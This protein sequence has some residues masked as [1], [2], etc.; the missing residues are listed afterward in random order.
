MLTQRQKD[1]FDFIVN[2]IADNGVSPTVSEIALGVGGIAHAGA[3]N[4]VKVLIKK[5]YIETIK[6]KHRSICIFP[7]EFR[8]STE[9]KEPKLK[10]ELT[11]DSVREIFEYRDGELFWKVSRGNVLEGRKAGVINKRGYLQLML[12]KKNYLGH[13]I[14]FLIHHGY[15]P[16]EIDH[17]DGNTRNNRI[18]N[19]RE[20]THEQNIANIGIRKTNTSGAKNV[21]YRERERKW[22]VA[23]TCNGKRFYG[24]RFSE[25]LAAK[26]A[27]DELRIKVHKEFANHGI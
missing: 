7:E 24:G 3:N 10:F 25:F 12:Q 18:E 22:E 5:G 13:R 11:P 6:N 26:S 23:V 20:A 17:I 9:K 19:L 4:F 16:A 8:K 2:Y 14:I 15:M 1:V 21:T 27:A